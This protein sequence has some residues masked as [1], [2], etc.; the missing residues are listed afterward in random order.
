MKYVLSLLA[1]LIISG[2]VLAINNESK[3]ISPSKVINVTDF[4]VKPDSRIN[5]VKGVR[6]AIEA[7]RGKEGMTIIFPKGRYDFWAQHC[8]EIEYYE[9]NTWDNYPRICPIVLKDIKGLTIDGNGSEFVY[10]GKMQPFTLDNC[11]GVTVKNIDIDW[12]IPLVGQSKIMKVEKKFIEIKI[13]PVMNP[14][15][16]VNGKIYFYGEG[17]KSDWWGCMEFENETRIIPQESADN[18]LGNNWRGYV[19]EELG[20]GLVRLNCDFNRKPKVGNYLIMRHSLR[21]HSGVFIYRSKDT[22]LENVTLFT[23]AGLGVLGQFSENI[24]LKNT[25]VI[26]NY[27]KG[28][29]LSGH[30]DGFQVSNCR[31]LIVVDGC[32]FEGLMDDPINVHGTS[33]KIIEVKG[34]SKVVC[35]YMH[36]MSTG[37]TWGGVGDKVAFI[38]NKS[39]VTVGYSKVT[40]NTKIDRDTFEVEFADAVPDGIGVGDALENLTWA[41]DFTVVNSV[42]GSCRARGLLVS[43]PGKVVIEN[44]DFISSGAAILIAGD[45][46]GWYESGAV[47]DVLIRG[48]RFHP[49][50]LTNWYQFGE[51]V[52][53]IYPIIPDFDKNRPFHRNIRIENNSFDMFDYSALYALSVD[54]LSFNNNTIKH[55]TLYKP[56]QGR[57]AM[58]TFEGC[59]DVQVKG[60]KIADDVLGKNISLIKMDAKEVTVGKGQKIKKL[61]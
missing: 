43:T 47:R 35:K 20:E 28:R 31:G 15:E 11:E 29:Y 40:A 55:N 1:V 21:E 6:A 48:N 49:S 13:D 51:G 14:Y 16:I 45:A 53:S 25:N 54:R 56:W 61:P 58:L 37:M 23:A 8:E 36:V 4:G 3:A 2:N 12:D 5:A 41:P 60:N 18:P 59:K 30:D 10:H 50:C 24:T 42:F 27:A 34:K 19:A 46:N 39:M 22:V 33:V 52:I 17:F 9:S 7:C 26:P 57:K 32:K 38:E 44:N